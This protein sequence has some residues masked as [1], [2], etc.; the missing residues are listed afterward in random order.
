MNISEENEQE[1]LCNFKRYFKDLKE[2]EE[3]RVDYDCKN[4]GLIGLM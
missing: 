4:R 3:G 2:R 1:W